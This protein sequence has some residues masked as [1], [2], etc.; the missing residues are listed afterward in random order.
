MS[1]EVKGA[2]KSKINLTGIILVILG[3]V[4]D[5]MFRSYFGDLIPPDWFGRI[6]FLAGWAVIYFRSN[7]QAN[8]SVDWKNPWKGLQAAVLIGL[9]SVCLTACATVSAVKSDATP[10]QTAQAVCSDLQTT[11]TAASAL[12]AWTTLYFPN[13]AA[14]LSEAS[15]YLSLAEESRAAACAAVDLVVDTESLASLVTTRQATVLT[16]IGKINTIVAKIKDVST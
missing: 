7:G 11:I 9:L 6:T 10:K 5:P 16:L 8:V 14:L 2:I 1:E 3:A 12:V 15:E 4:T 13:Q